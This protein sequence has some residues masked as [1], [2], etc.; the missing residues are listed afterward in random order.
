MNFNS[1]DDILDFAIKNEE[2]AYKFYLAL[3]E[4]TKPSLKSTFEDF[5][6]EELKHKEMILKVKAGGE[7]KP[8]EDKIMDLKILESLKREDKIENYSDLEYEDALKIAMKREKETFL[9]YTKLADK[10]ENDNLR[11]LFL[12]LAQEEAKH[13]LRF[14]IAYDEYIYGEN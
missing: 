9:F 4:K 6:R 13:K 8:I 10:M 5:A 12:R 2:E 3:A 11:N 7:L 14:E 1:V